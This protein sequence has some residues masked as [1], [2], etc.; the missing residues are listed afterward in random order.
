LGFESIL[1]HEHHVAAQVEVHE[2]SGNVLACRHFPIIFKCPDEK[3][4]NYNTIIKS[5]Q[6]AELRRAGES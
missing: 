1:E 2:A 4:A 3:N 6:T 5:L